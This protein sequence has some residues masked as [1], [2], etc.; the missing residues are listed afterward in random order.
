[1]QN[2]LSLGQPHLWEIR[3]GSF[4]LFLFLLLLPRESKVNSQ[5]W[6]RLG[7]WQLYKCVFM[8]TEIQLPC[9][10]TLF[11]L[12]DTLIRGKHLKLLYKFKYMKEKGV[13]LC[14]LTLR[15]VLSFL[16]MTLY[17]RYICHS[18]EVHRGYN[19]C[20]MIEREGMNILL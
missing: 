16:V 20:T 5:F 8:Y 15:L 9:N 11:F 10:D 18:R 4:F 2:F 12:M 14:F 19:H 17:A 6:T 1:M 13:W 3:W 7:V